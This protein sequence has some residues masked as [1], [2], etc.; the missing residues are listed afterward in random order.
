MVHAAQLTTFAPCREASIWCQRTACE[1][2]YC[3]IKPCV[4]ESTTQCA[5]TREQRVFLLATQSAVGLLGSCRRRGC[6]CVSAA[7]TAA[8]RGS[9]GGRRGLAAQVM[10][11]DR[12]E[13]TPLLRHHHQLMSCPAIL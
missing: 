8:K 4:G 1:V 9:Q 11:M 13:V 7:G 6:S 5:C 12:V 10:N 2:G 3:V